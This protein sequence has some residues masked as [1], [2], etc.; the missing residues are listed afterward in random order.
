MSD[1]IVTERG[2]EIHIEHPIFKIS[3]YVPDSG[4]PTIKITVPEPEHLRK[5]SSKVGE[6]IEKVHFRTARI[7]A[8]WLP[9]D[10]PYWRERFNLENFIQKIEDYTRFLIE[11]SCRDLEELL[12][13][14][15]LGPIGVTLSDFQRKDELKTK[16]KRG[17]SSYEYSVSF[18]G[19]ITFEP[20]L[21]DPISQHLSLNVLKERVSWYIAV[22]VR[23]FV[24]ERLKNAGGRW[25]SVDRVISDSEGI[26]WWKAAPRLNIVHTEPSEW[27]FYL[28]FRNHN[29]EQIESIFRN[30][31]VRVTNIFEL[32]RAIY[33]VASLLNVE[34]SHVIFNKGRQKAPGRDGTSLSILIQITDEL[35]ELVKS[36]GGD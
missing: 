13:K 2:T 27:I 32:L 8:S 14:Y 28:E 36:H 20:P 18:E 23:D 3:L 25:V 30:L 24:E 29:R 7:I 26:L 19:T 34:V 11:K 17:S 10:D 35:E 9:P 31:L 33:G 1:F 5:R 15:E 12:K 6:G 21:V 4:V 22:N 16:R